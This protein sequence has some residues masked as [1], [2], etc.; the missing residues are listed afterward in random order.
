MAN[1]KGKNILIFGLGRFGETILNELLKTGIKVRAVEMSEKV[2]NY[3]GRVR[4]IFSLDCTN[5][6]ALDEADIASSD[7][8]II[9]FGEGGFEEKLSIVDFLSS[10]WS[11]KQMAEEL[12]VRTSSLK[13]EK[14]LRNYGVSRI[15]F[16]ERDEGMRVVKGI[17]WDVTGIEDHGD[18]YY[19]AHHRTFPKLVGKTVT[20]SHLRVK[21]HLNLVQIKREDGHIIEPPSPGD[22]LE[23]NDILSIRGHENAITEFIGDMS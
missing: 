18:G 1:L 6:N 10:R 14:I 17:L 16:P 13:R 15:V 20:D 2:D 4:D 7:K 23:K 11:P 5:D 19:T 12:I 22:L 21:Y 9:S 8:I 3:K